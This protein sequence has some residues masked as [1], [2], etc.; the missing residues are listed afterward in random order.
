M[1]RRWWQKEARANAEKAA[2]TIATEIIKVDN[3]AH[4][5]DV[6]DVL[7]FTDEIAS[8]I[9]DAAAALV[10]AVVAIEPDHIDNSIDDQV[11]LSV[12]DVKVA[13]ITMT[14]NFAQKNNKNKRR[15]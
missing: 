11:D 4:E 7:Q 1:G 3:T 12:D 15:R 14:H 10:N 6:S 13:G 8:N 9:E 5:N 2:Q